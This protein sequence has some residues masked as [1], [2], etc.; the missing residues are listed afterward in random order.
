MTAKTRIATLLLAAAVLAAVMVIG[1]QPAASLGFP[2]D[3]AW[4][5]MVY[6]RSLATE[7]LLAYNP[8]VPSTGCTA[9]L[10][11]VCVGLSHLLLGGVSIAAMVTGVMALGV[12][13]HLLGI[14]LA[15]DLVFLITGRRLAALVAGVVLAVSPPLAEGSISGMEIALCGMLLVASVRALW[16]GQWRRA[17]IWFALCGLARP[18]SVVPAG[19]CLALILIDLSRDRGR[20]PWREAIALLVPGLL[21]AGLM[22]GHNLAATGRWLPATFYFKQDSTL[23]DLPGRLVIGVHGLLDQVPPFWG[24]ASWLALAGFVLPRT[25]LRILLP[26]AAG[27]GFFTANLLVARPVDPS[28]FYH[29][30]YLLPAVPILTVAVC[31]GADRLGGLVPARFR[32]WPVAGVLILGLVG[33]A[34]TL[35]PV[36]KRYHNDVRNI[37]EVQVRMGDWLKYNTPADAWLAASDAGAVRY[38]SR[39]PVVDLMGLNTPEFYWDQERYVTEH[40]VD[41]LAVM[42]V[43]FRPTDGSRIRSYAVMETGNYTVTSFADMNTQTILAIPDGKEPVVLKLSGLRDIEVLVRPGRVRLP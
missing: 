43:W 5:H 1:R 10:W 21:L 23:L 4:I 31:V 3:D 37:N 16:L 27:L 7:G 24:W 38:F 15:V 17:G 39:R 20:F 11:A 6:G 13:W 26:A 19:I 22:A 2:L 8:G 34:W 30:R 28:I 18:E 29:L 9:P 33:G 12:T 25:S 40:P 36:S 35:V 42:L 41:A 14:W 32:L